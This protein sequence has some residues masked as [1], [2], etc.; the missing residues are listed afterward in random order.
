MPE[1]TRF[2]GIVIKMYF[3]SGEHEPSIYAI[4]NEFLGKFNV[5]TSEI[6]YGDLPEK[7]QNIVCE[8]IEMYKKDLQKMWD[9]KKIIPLPPIV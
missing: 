1:I 7:A 8:W 6:I 9:S 2:Y 5:L 4:Y 3:R